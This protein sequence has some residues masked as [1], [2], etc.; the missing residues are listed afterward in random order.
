[1]LI[2]GPWSIG[3]YKKAGVDFGITRIPKVDETGLWSSPMVAIK[4][5]SINVN[6]DESKM[7]YVIEFFKYLVSPEIQL[8][9][10]RVLGNDTNT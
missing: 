10:T 8:E 1:M 4:G 9:H 3:G 5:Y 6:V 7:P 2:N